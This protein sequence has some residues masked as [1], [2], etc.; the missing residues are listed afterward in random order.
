METI[1]NLESVSSAKINFRH[2]VICQEDRGDVMTKNPW[3]L[4]YATLLSKVKERASY[5]VTKYMLL[6]KALGEETP[7]TLADKGGK[8]V[9]QDAIKIA[10]ETIDDQ[11]QI[12]WK[13]SNMI[14][15]DILKRNKENLSNRTP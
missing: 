2:C 5:L 14:R 3:Q 10:S 1:A 15:N 4:S 7:S 11:L 13:T 12:I 6:Q 8:H 9:L